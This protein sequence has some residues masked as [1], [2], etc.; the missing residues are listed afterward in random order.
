ML[1]THCGDSHFYWRRFGRGLV[2]GFRIRGRV[3]VA[4]VSQTE[5][6]CCRIKVQKKI[7]FVMWLRMT[8]VCWQH[9]TTCDR[10]GMC[11]YIT[12]CIKHPIAQTSTYTHALRRRHLKDRQWKPCFQVRKF[13]GC[14]FTLGFEVCGWCLLDSLRASTHSN[15]STTV[16][17]YLYLSI[18]SHTLN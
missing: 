11:S 1:F 3:M 16:I 15:W 13:L 4:R 12:T 9:S 14:D 10:G 6:P 17:I 8:D 7:A 2:S 5:I 18:T